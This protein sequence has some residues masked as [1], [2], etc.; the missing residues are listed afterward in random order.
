MT[1]GPTEPN[2]EQMQNYL[3]I[4]VDDLIKLYEEGIKIA[5]PAHPEGRVFCCIGE[6]QLVNNAIQAF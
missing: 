3:K 2:A 5:T 4:I 1:P 6:A